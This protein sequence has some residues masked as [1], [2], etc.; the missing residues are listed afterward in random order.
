VWRG[1]GHTGRLCSACIEGHA[2][3]GQ[4]C[5]PCDGTVSPVVKKTLGFT[6]T[7]LIVGLLVAW[8]G[9]PYFHE[10]EQII[11][12]AIS[13]RSLQVYRRLN[14]KYRKQLNRQA[15]KASR[16]LDKAQSKIQRNIEIQVRTGQGVPA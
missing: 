15:S 11:T 13:A 9:R 16:G 6:F 14:S 4:Y 1:A 8:L 12:K 7:L 5:L 2:I 3:Q 10:K